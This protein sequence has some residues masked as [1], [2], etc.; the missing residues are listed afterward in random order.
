MSAKEQIREQTRNQ[1]RLPRQYQVLIYNDDFTPMDLVVN[2]LVQIFN[3]EEE[4]AF[5][6]MM[7]VHRGSCAVVGIY[8][9]DIAQ[10]KADEAVCWA[11]E[12]GY[13]LKVEAVCQ[14]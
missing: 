6:L 14:P 13:P 5:S 1:T 10:I 2:I 9:K 3:K 8:P 7:Q 11:R 4:E 12:E